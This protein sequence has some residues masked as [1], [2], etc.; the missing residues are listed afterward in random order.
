MQARD[1]SDKQSGQK[2]KAEGESS[3][4]RNRY[5]VPSPCDDDVLSEYRCPITQELPVDPVVAEDGQAYERSAIEDW[6]DRQKGGEVK[7][8]ALV[9]LGL[10]CANFGQPSWHLARIH[11]CKYA[12]IYRYMHANMH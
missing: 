11:A 10:T 9:K 2:R 3:R 5:R 12:L 8:T 4:E 1:S 6:F 7:S